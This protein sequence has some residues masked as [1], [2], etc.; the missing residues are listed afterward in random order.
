MGYNEGYWWYITLVGERMRTRKILPPCRS[1]SSIGSEIKEFRGSGLKAYLQ[2][3]TG[4]GVLDR[5]GQ[6]VIS[7]GRRRIVDMGG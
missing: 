1:F 5:K 2:E 6:E 3:H 7:S 4:S